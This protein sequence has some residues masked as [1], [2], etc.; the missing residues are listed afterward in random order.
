MLLFNRLYRLL[1]TAY[2][3]FQNILCY[4]LTHIDAT[5]AATYVEFQNI[6]CYCLTKS[7]HFSVH[8]F[9]SFQNIL[10]YCLTAKALLVAHNKIAF[11][12]ILC[13]CLTWR[14]LCCN[15]CYT[16]ISKHP[17]L[18]FNKFLPSQYK[19][20]RLISKHPMLL[21][22]LAMLYLHCC[23]LHFKTSYVTV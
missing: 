20:Y 15:S 10:C 18:L 4:C 13:Y 23:Q 8:D 19:S 12:N 9:F 7:F 21:F 6:L 16:G 22:N 5:A 1:R 3:K 14:W 11:Q 2:N 17:M